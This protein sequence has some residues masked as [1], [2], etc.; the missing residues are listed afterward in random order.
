M[1]AGRARSGRHEA[2]GRILQY[3]AVIYNYPAALV[4]GKKHPNMMGQ[5]YRVAW[6]EVWDTIKVAIM[7]VL[8]EGRVIH[9]D[10]ITFFFERNGYTEESVY[11][12]ACVPCRDEHGNIAGCVTPDMQLRCE[13]GS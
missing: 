4:A 7:S 8:K 3:F 10:N 2:D 11:S 6:G 1:R 5:L 13:V 9:M 12:Y